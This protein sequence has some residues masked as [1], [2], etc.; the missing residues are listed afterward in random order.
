MRNNENFKSRFIVKDDPLINSVYIGWNKSFDFARL[1]KQRK[2]SW[3]SRIYEYAFV[4]LCINEAFCFKLIKPDRILDMACG[5]NHPGYVVIANIYMVKYVF[6]LDKNEEL[7]ANTMSH[8][9]V[10]KVIGDA[11]KTRFDNDFFDAIAC[12]S[13]L[14]HMPNWRACIREMHRLL[15]PGGMAF[16]TM[17]ISTDPVKTAKHDVDD[18]T[19]ADYA[20]EFERSGLKIFGD[21]DDHLPDD[22]VDAICSKYPLAASESELLDG[23]HRELKTFRMVFRKS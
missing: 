16:V 21:Y 8:P 10:K 15:K 20:N 4:K 2:R 7:L 18:K 14:E 11:I 1:Q 23:Q 13:A 22:A 6:A 17:D 19:P 9:R 5:I 12:V 3:H